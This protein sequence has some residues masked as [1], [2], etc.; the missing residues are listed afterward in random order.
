MKNS[1]LD[2]HRKQLE[3]V[4]DALW[5]VVEPLGT[6]KPTGAFYFLVP[7]PKGITEEE[8]V[9]ILARKYGVLLMHGKPFGCE[10][11]LR[12]S[13]GSIPPD[14]VLTAIDSLHSGF[15]FLQRLSEER[16]QGL[17]QRQW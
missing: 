10:G 5:P 11:H 16:S 14:Q 2:G 13:Y 15:S 6:V 9:D 3:A 17:S 12:L 4:R 8:A 7:V 1:W